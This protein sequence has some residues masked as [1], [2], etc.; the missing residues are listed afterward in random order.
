MT[1][2]QLNKGSKDLGEFFLSKWPYY[3]VIHCICFV[4]NVPNPDTTDRIF[5]TYA[6]DLTERVIFD[7]EIVRWKS[8]WQQLALEKPLTLQDTLCLKNK[9]LYPNVTAILKIILRM[10]VSTATSGTII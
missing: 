10:P 5:C 2:S 3:P 9:Q 6:N 7:G 4:E 1:V 8:K